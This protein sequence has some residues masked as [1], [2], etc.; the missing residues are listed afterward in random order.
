MDSDK[1]LK[2]FEA[3]VKKDSD[4]FY[5]VA[6]AVIEEEQRKKHHL[7]AKRLKQIL[8]GNG[9]SSDITISHQLPPV[10]RDNEK[11]FRKR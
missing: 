5:K 4:S 10:P 11:G 6:L 3:F 1:L 8:N 7:L 2:V 9:I